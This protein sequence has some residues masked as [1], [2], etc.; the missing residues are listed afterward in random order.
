[1][2]DLLQK[3]SCLFFKGQ[4]Q[5]YSGRDM[6]RRYSEDNVCKNGL[7]S[8]L[9][10]I[11]CFAK[12]VRF[13]SIS[14]ATWEK[15]NTESKKAFQSNDTETALR[16]LM[17]LSGIRVSAASAILAWAKPEKFGIFDSRVFQTL[18]SFGYLK[19]GYGRDL[20]REWKK[21]SENPNKSIS[22]YL[23]YIELI[24]GWSECLNRSCQNID[25]WLYNY[26]KLCSPSSSVRL[27]SNSPSQAARPIWSE[28]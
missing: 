5:L 1:M 10:A 18:V 14:E 26:A 17:D 27:Y 19:I 23:K 25:V 13:Q 15:L 28:S 20:G 6:V 7:S 3:Y 12:G 2:F 9:F 21:I 4:G 24:S 11:T 8:E 22:V 16:K